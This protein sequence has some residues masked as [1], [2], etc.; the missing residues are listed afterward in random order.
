MTEQNNV[1]KTM[2]YM[3][4]ER[5]KGELASVLQTY[6]NEEEN[7]HKMRDAIKEFETLVEYN[8]LQE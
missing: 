5:A 6:W 7:Y 4:W 2:R 1:I 8:G 3:A